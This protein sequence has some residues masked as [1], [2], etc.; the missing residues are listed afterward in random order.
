MTL[1]ELRRYAVARAFAEPTDLVTAIQ[2]LGYLQADPIRAP[3]RAQDLI[4]RHR[5]EN[6][7]ADDLEKRF[8]DLPVVEDM[9]HNYGFF[10]DEHRALLY[11]RMMSA[12]WRDFID[13]HAALRRKVLRHFIEYE[14]AHPRDVERRLGGGARINGWGGASTATTLMLEALH[15]EGRLRVA[16]R[17]AGIRVYAPAHARGPALSQLARADGIIR[18]IVNLYAPISQRS[19]MRTFYMMGVYKPD[20][21]YLKRVELMVKRGEFRREMVDAVMYVW[22]ANE[23]N[24]HAVTDGVRLL[25]PFDPLVWDRARF[26]HLWGWA[27][28]FEAYTPLAKRKLGY[29]ALPMLCRDRIVG[30]ANASIEDGRLKIQTGHAAAKPRGPGLAAFN[31][32]L[33]DEAERVRLFLGLPG[34]ARLY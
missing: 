31:S 14:E 6:Y 17:D 25:A 7:R 23:T 33:K 12:R 34:R 19:L 9:L 21:D 27:Y 28:R 3:A 1:D 13:E 16:R 18:L 29:Y 10:P 30:W 22:P 4:L 15:R 26:E 8:P 11:P 32:S 20:V 2:R 5:V 24:P